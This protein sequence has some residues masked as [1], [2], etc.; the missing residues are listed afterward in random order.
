MQNGYDY[1]KDRHL[2]PRERPRIHM[3]PSL[4]VLSLVTNIVATALTLMC[5][6]TPV[7][8]GMRVAAVTQSSACQFLEAQD[9]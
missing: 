6:S 4:V 7:R 1:L 8:T 3:P 5:V 2:M 9:H